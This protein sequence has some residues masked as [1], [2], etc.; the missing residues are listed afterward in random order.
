[1]HSSYK[2]PQ[3]RQLAW[4]IGA[5]P[6]YPLTGYQAFEAGPDEDIQP[7]LAQLDAQPAPLLSF[8]QGNT[9]PLL[10]ARFE[11]YLQFFCQYG[12]GN[13]LLSANLQVSENGIT[14]GEFDLL[15]RH[16]GQHLHLE[17]AV[18]FYLC[19]PDADGSDPA[20]WY[21]PQNHDR[22]DL[23]LAKLGQQ[24]QLANNRAGIA[25][26]Q[27]AGINTAPQPRY[28]L[29]GMLFSPWNSPCQNPAPV[30]HQG[31]WLWLSQLDELLSMGNEW[32]LLEKT[33]WLGAVIT[34][35][36]LNPAQVK[37][38]LTAHFAGKGFARMLTRHVEDGCAE[39]ERYMLVH[40]N[41]PL[42]S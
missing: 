29:N 16:G 28:L 6:L 26:L 38:A 13:Q 21:G 10:G 19:L 27:A 18:K 12:P 42:K 40:N 33:D 3:V 32:L 22:L 36:V 14:R 15:Y 25:A 17:A 4:C 35:L 7:W 31:K 24:L 37:S 8:L 34:P 5:A 9:S 11:S 20:H 1:M 39:T 2:T 30:H 23:K 41:W